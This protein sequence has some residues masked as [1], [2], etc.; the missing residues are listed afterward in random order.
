[1]GKVTPRIDDTIV[2]DPPL[3]G[4]NNIISI[5][6]CAGIL[7]ETELL[8]IDEPRIKGGRESRFILVYDQY[9]YPEKLIPFRQSV[10]RVHRVA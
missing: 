3:M 8:V 7:S 6:R 9:G 2:L 1:M 10:F 4:K 5:V